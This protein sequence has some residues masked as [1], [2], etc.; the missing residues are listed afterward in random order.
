[1]AGDGRRRDVERLAELVRGA[2]SVVAL[3][4][5]GISVPSGIPDF[6]SPGTGLWENV[7][8]ME[9]AHIDAFRRDP[10]AL[11]ALLRRPLPR[12]S[13]TSEPNG[14]HLA[15]AELERR[16]VLDAVVTQNIDLLHR[17]AGTQR[18]RRGPRDDRALVVPGV[19]RAVPARR[20][21][22]A[23]RGRRRRRRAALRLRRAAEARRRAVRRVPA[24]GR[25]GAG[26]RAGRAAPT[27]C[28]ASARRSRS[29]RSRSCR[30]LTRQAGGAVAIVTAG[31]DAVRRA[32]GGA[33]RRRR[34]RRARGA[35]RGVVGRLAGARRLA[36][37][38]VCCAS[39]SGLVARPRAPRGRS[40]VTYA[41]GSPIRRAPRRRS[42]AAGTCSARPAAVTFQAVAGGAPTRSASLE[43]AERDRLPRRRRAAARRA[44]A[45]TASRTGQRRRAAL[46]QVAVELADGTERVRARAS[47]LDR[48]RRDARRRRPVAPRSRAAPGSDT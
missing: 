1:M 26:V 13:T 16:G 34:G 15:L 43:R 4:G 23:A 12:R 30:T 7:D 3:T 22:R 19:R 5:A 25:D 47:L 24:R 11:L 31:P 28:C 17:K 41:A 14:A 9:V 39:S 10:A 2:D 37:V 33:A 44:R 48:A 32:R 29:T 21:A 38:R 35:R 40:T 20:G 46:A 27:C 42:R 36:R 45:A 18:A 6:R 8:P